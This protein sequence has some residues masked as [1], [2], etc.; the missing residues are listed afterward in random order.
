MCIYA[1]VY[2]YVYVCICM[3]VY[4]YIYMKN[5][6]WEDQRQKQWYIV[7]IAPRGVNSAILFAYRTGY[8]YSKEPEGLQKV[9]LSPFSAG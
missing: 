3:C 8:V 5:F 6:A 4:I 9:F 1:C 7:H 2:V